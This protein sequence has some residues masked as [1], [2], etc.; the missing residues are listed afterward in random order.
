MSNIRSQNQDMDEA[1]MKITK[2][3][4]AT[5]AIKS[6][7]NVMAI[8]KK[9]D[10]YCPGCRGI[11]EETVEQIAICNGLDVKEFVEELNRAQE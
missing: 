2:Q 9:Y 6:S 7:K 1:G 5:E 8:F 3:T 4:R 10:L 11:A